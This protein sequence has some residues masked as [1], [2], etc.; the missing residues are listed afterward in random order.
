LSK[1][2]EGPI[3]RWGTFNLTVDYV[4]WQINKVGVWGKVERKTPFKHLGPLQER[5]HVPIKGY[6]KLLRSQQYRPEGQLNNTTLEIMAGL[7]FSTDKI[8]SGF[9][10]F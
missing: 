4:W 3:P 9:M 7:L 10:V 8:S 6:Y 1:N 5:R 2:L